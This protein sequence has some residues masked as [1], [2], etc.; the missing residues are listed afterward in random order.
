M[1]PKQLSPSHVI[2]G[3]ALLHHIPWSHGATFAHS[4]GDCV[5]KKYGKAQ[6]VF[7][8]YIGASTK[9]MADRRRA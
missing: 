2:D 8:G 9:D 1:L 4:Y 5:V 6:I 7:D 3:G